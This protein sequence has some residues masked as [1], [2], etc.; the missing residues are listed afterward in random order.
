MT[1]I[2]GPDPRELGHRFRAAA[3]VGRLQAPGMG[4]HDFGTSAALG[5]EPDASPG[6]R[7]ENA[8]RR[9]ARPLLLSRGRMH[10]TDRAAIWNTRQAH[11]SR[12]LL[13]GCSGLICP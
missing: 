13:D 6:A 7:P 4:P 2:T 10:A 3:T 12:G 1:Q 11:E 5:N 8:C 9:G